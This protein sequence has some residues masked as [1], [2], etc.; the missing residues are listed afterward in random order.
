[1]KNIVSIIVLS[2]FSLVMVSGQKFSGWKKAETEHF[3]FIYED[4]ARPFADE[5]ALYADTAWTD[6]AKIYGFPKDKLDIYITHRTNTVNAYTYSLPLEIVMFTSPVITPEF[7]FRDNWQKLFFT[8]ELIHAANMKFEGKSNPL[9]Y[10]MGPI[11]DSVGISDIPG[12]GLEGL[13]TV[14]ET[15]LTKGGRGRSPYFEL[16]YKA[17]T[18]DNGF[19]SYGEI[20]QDA[21]PPAGQSYVMGYIIMRSIA[22]RWGLQALA[23]IERNRNDTRNWESSIKFVTGCTPQDIYRDARISLAKKFYGERAIP[24]GQIISP[25][26]NFYNYYK[27]SVVFDDGSFIALKSSRGSTAVVRFDPSAI[28]GSNWYLDTDAKKDLNTVYKETVLFTAQF[29]DST[30][31]TAD[32]NGTVYAS[33]ALQR[34]DRNPGYEVDYPLYKFTEETGLV[35]LTNGASLFQPAVSRDGKVLVAVQQ[36]GLK[37][38]LVKV[39]T[40]SGEIIPILWDEKINYI[41]PQVNADGTKI[42]FLAV[43]DERA[44]VCVMNVADIS[45]ASPAKY[46]V[47]Y[48]GSGEIVDPAYPSWNSNG[49]ITFSCNTRGR[50]EVFEA[51]ASRGGYSVKPVIADPIG[52]LWAYQTKKGVLYW[53]YSSSGYVIK[54]KPSS[55]WGKVPSFNGPS[56]PGTIAK[57]GN[58]Q[59]DYPDFVPFDV[60]SE[61]LITKEER[62]EFKANLIKR[63]TEK[64]DENDEPTPVPGKYVEPRSEEFKEKAEN[65]PE[66]GTTLGKGSTYIPGIQPIF[67]IPTFDLQEIP[68]TNKRRFGIGGAFVALTPRLQMN[69]GA[70]FANFNYFPKLKNFEGVM[71]GTIPTGASTFAYWVSRDFSVIELS[72]T[73]NFKEKNTMFVG[74]TVPLYNREQAKEYSDLSLIA[75]VEGSIVRTA[76]SEFSVTDKIGASY[77]LDLEAG[78]DYTKTTVGPRDVSTKL[79]AT[80]LAIA[81]YSVDRNKVFVGGEGE[82]TYTAD[83]QGSLYELSARF[84]YTNFPV[85]ENNF[86]TRAKISGYETNNLFPGKIVLR[87]GALFPNFMLGLN[88]KFYA[89]TLL[90]F[91]E[92]TVDGGTPSVSSIFGLQLPQAFYF[93]GELGLTSGRAELYGGINFCYDYTQKFDL[94][95]YKLYFTCK[96][97]WFRL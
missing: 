51:T 84:R 78:L 42:T 38:Q 57:F 63:I 59:N 8:H 54:I 11:V 41:E 52:A 33:I 13:T 53:S 93:G 37:M 44:K 49:N 66:P 45:D 5:Y 81:L 9:S 61:K 39:D 56:M 20:G 26:N 47:V 36:N 68:N 96:Y 46:T 14:L 71:G 29:G 28:Y 64:S 31:V 85:A 67:Y 72:G 65:L 55:E 97:D 87:T 6:I 18:M 83:Q 24:E 19:I 2:L 15:E 3:R 27:P 88:G 34:K 22:D 21:V 91:G 94:K 95:N 50:L 82:I 79:D 74:Y 17:P 7:G 69:S 25:R 75:A 80:A 23:D 32:E 10:L 76:A 60:P 40:E 16:M 12:W 73:E 1:M 92:N 48:N 77:S 4:A 58:L 35:Q 43:E 89:E 30:A 86:M 70:L 62:D 90:N